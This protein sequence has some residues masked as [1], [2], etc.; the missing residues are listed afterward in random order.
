MG[1][2][3][4]LRTVDVVA[5][6][7]VL[8]SLDNAHGDLVYSMLFLRYLET[9]IFERVDLRKGKRPNLGPGLIW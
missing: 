9:G 1:R 5:L 8:G 3:R 4:S 6:R 2:R 7:D